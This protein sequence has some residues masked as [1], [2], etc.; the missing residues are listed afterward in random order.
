MLLFSLPEKAIY[1]AITAIKGAAYGGARRV[2][3]SN[4]TLMYSNH[5]HPISTH[6]MRHTRSI[7]YIFLCLLLAA[8]ALQPTS[9]A[10]GQKSKNAPAVGKAG[11]PAKDGQKKAAS[12]SS[13]ERVA[14]SDENIFRLLSEDETNLRFNN[15]VP[16]AKSLKKQSQLFTIAAGGVSVGDVNNDGLP[17]IYLTRFMNPNKLYI[18]KGNLKFEEAPP[19]AGVADSASASFGSTMVDIDGDG[20]LDIYVSEYNFTP[21]R[22]FINNGDGT[23]TDKAKEF[24]LDFVGNSI[25]ATFFDYD[26]DGDLDMYLVVNGQSEVDY[27]SRGELSKFYKNNGNNTFTEVSQQIGIKHKGFGLSASVADYNNDGWLDLYVANDF[28]APDYLYYNNGD[29]TFRNGTKTATR[30]TSYFSMGSDAADVN[31]DGLMDFLSVDMLP[32]DHQRRNTQFETVSIFSTLHDSSQMLKNSLQINRGDGTFS[33]IGYM[34]GTAMTDWSWCPLI[35]DFNNDGLKDIFV[36]NGIKYDIMD[37]DAIRFAANPEVLEKMGLHEL[38]KKMSD[39]TPGSDR[40]MGKNLDLDEYFRKL[41]RTRI[42]NFLFR[43]DGGLQFENASEEW[44]FTAP[45]NNTVA[46][47]YADLDN[48]GDL[49]MILNNIDTMATVYRNTTREKGLGNYLQVKLIGKGKNTEGLGAKVEITIR[50]THQNIQLSRT[51]GFASSVDALVHFGIGKEKQVDELTVTWLSGAKQTIKNSK[52]NQRLVLKEENA[53]LTDNKPPAAEP[54]ILTPVPPEKSLVFNHVEN[55]YDDFFQE[56]LL[57]NKLSTNGPGMATGD[58]NGDGLSDVF[59]GGP[60]GIIPS[61]YLQRPD[62]R[63]TLSVQ[64]AFAP[65]SMCEDQGALFFDADG[66][67]DLDLYVASGGN[68]ESVETPKLLADRLYI[69]DG[70]GTFSKGQ[71]SEM[72]TSTS[73]VLAGDMD[74]DGD[75]DLFVGGRNVPGKYPDLPR[76]YLLLNEH[77]TFIDVTEQLCSELKNP[78]MVTSG[79]WTDYNND[80]KLDLILVGEWMTPRIFQN[81]GGTFREV[82]AG[83]GLDSAYGWWNSINAGDFD[84]DGDIDYVVGNLGL[85]SRY[86]ATQKYPIEMYCNDVDENGSVEILLTYYNNGLQYP[87][88]GISLMYAQIPTL[89]KKVPSATQ[90]AKLEFREIFPKEKI[91]SAVYNKATTFANSYLE[92]KGN[93][94]F[95][96]HLLPV[97][98]Q[99]APVFGSSVQDYDGDGNLDLLMVDNFYG[100]DR[101]MWRYDS[102]E[103]LFLHG[104][105]KGEFEVLPSAKSGLFNP[106]DARSVITFPSADSN[107]Y[108]LIGNNTS[109]LKVY[110]KDV[111]NKKQSILRVNGKDGYTYA[112][113]T[114]KNGKTRRHE[115]YYGAGYLSQSSLDILL[116]PE[117][118]SVAFYKGSTIQKTV[119]VSQQM[120]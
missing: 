54:T 119:T 3:D 99:V 4:T 118:K 55:I 51:R 53:V 112:I 110:K 8:G 56:R 94:R 88:R 36:S 19:S 33:D 72:F 48:D 20:D 9:V 68:E 6:T 107:L 81:T 23:F 85:N 117:V 29:G 98:A 42:N 66:D 50:D 24:G 79:L 11:T 32:A 2:A 64:P 14:A 37:R 78:G 17:D 57:P 74:G 105:G 39:T 82:T 71:L 104:D 69:N 13:P 111:S 75:L 89:N 113:L 35:A 40:M 101:E 114:L 46:A 26:K 41:P 73:C 27:E 34:T 38:A 92:N 103:G 1:H 21:N 44:G 25:Q 93:G 106:Y 77:G 115:F 86:K 96:I 65:D 67:G 84:N 90:Y 52:A 18:N 58:V 5:Y 12:K 87:L 63:F 47:A 61:L 60:Q 100:P 10:A 83:S 30:H 31:N 22:L 95:S 62:G 28:E 97:M 102:G 16:G 49:D 108:I 80:G 7:T 109:P 43:N 45:Y 120:R 91:D 76:S 15:F 59:I 116:S 70:K